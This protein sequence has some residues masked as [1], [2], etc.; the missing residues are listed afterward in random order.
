MDEPACIICNENYKTGLVLIKQKALSRLIESSKARLDRKY[1]Q[2]EKLESA[3]VHGSCSTSYNKESQIQK[4]KDSIGQ[5]MSE[6]KRLSGEARQ[7]NFNENC[8]FC[9]AIC[10]T[11]KQ[12]ISYVQTNDVKTKIIAETS[13]RNKNEFKEMLLRL[14]S[15]Q[16]LQGACYHRV[17]MCNFYTKTSNAQAGRPA[18]KETVDFMDKLYLYLAEH[19]SECQ[20]FLNDV[21][22]EIGGE[23]PEWRTVKAKLEVKF[24]NQLLFKVI[25]KQHVIFFKNAIDDT[26]WKLWYEKRGQDRAEERKRIVDMAAKIILE[27]ICTMEI[28]THFYDILDPCKEESWFD[29]LVPSSLRSFLKHLI[30]TNKDKNSKSYMKWKKRVATMSHS[31]I[32]SVRPRS[33]LSPIMQGLASYLHKRSSSRHLVEAFSYVGLCSSYGETL[34]FEASISKDPANH[35]VSNDAYVQYIYDNFD[36][37]TR[38]L[39]GKN[40]V[41]IMAGG[42]VVTPSSMVTSKQ[43][44][45][46]LD[47]IPAAKDVSI[48]GFL[49]LQHYEKKK[50]G[51]KGIEIEP[52][53]DQNEEKTVTTSMIDLS[54]Q[55]S[56]YNDETSF[57]WNGFMESAHVSN[58]YQTS[59]VLFLPFVNNPPSDYDTIFTVMAE[60]ARDNNQHYKLKFV[61]ITLDQQLWIK[62]REILASIDPENDPLLLLTIRLRLGGF[63][64]LMSH[65]GSIGYI[66]DGSGLKEALSTAYASNSVDV[67][68]NGHAYARAIR[69]HFLVHLALSNIV[70]ASIEFSD[71]E[72]GKLDALLTSVG[73][74]EFESKL[75]LEDYNFLQKK[76]IDQLDKLKT[77]GP[78]AKLM[79]QYME[80]VQIVK[81]FIR[82]ERTGNFDLHADTYELMIPFF[83]ASGHKNYVKSGHL[84]LQ[85]LKKLKLEMSSVEYALF[86]D[87]G[88]F[89]VRRSDRCWSGVWTD[90][91]VEQVIMRTLKIDGGVTGVGRMKD[92]VLSKF[93]RNM[94]VLTEVC[95]GMESFCNVNFTTSEQHVDT[96]EYRITRD[97]VDLKKNSD[98]F[99]KYNPFPKTD[100]ITS[101]YSGVVGDD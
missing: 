48:D 12:D 83:H 54:W 93:V 55:Y 44:I 38:N 99:I 87:Q 9:G 29:G 36:H 98:F 8:F 100:K 85:D 49:P 17:C 81:D 13:K 46:R 91:I 1:T 41:H 20:F 101:I 94:V 92:T 18:S 16:N 14:N 76:Y 39:D 67:M 57:G 32:S 37:N 79:I 52:I 5:K 73:R 89:T 59:K 63:H 2:F 95:N 65:L 66:M 31:L 10:Y 78:T 69:G 74:E 71:I 3:Y 97:V 30:C 61:F 82:A 24:P 47:E 60:S 26:M 84:Y 53:F 7:F 64:T 72:K 6:G 80:M 96:R 21:H 35:T 27:D 40:T 19:R 28:D 68:M 70:F 22:K 11:N 23:C 34:R 15:V 88:Y 77:N 62:A 86:A 43:K 45:A 51:L 90:M 33:F 4:A 56:K 50:D 25:N 58:Q 42:K 75:K